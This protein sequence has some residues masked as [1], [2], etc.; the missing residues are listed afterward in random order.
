MRW[1]AAS[2]TLLRPRKVSTHTHTLV[3]TEGIETT[4]VC[5]VEVRCTSIRAGVV[6]KSAPSFHKGGGDSIQ[7]FGWM[8]RKWVERRRPRASPLLVHTLCL[9]RWMETG[10]VETVVIKQTG[11][12]HRHVTRYQ[13]IRTGNISSG[14][15]TPSY[16]LIETIQPIFIFK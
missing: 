9:S 4:V 1:L 5:Y 13:D 16:L 7:D 14:L 12:Q 15:S 3:H 11:A 10:A 6:T 8:D 2:L